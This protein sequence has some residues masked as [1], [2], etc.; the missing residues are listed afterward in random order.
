MMFMN[1]QR[2]MI[3]KVN[4]DVT[5]R[6]SDLEDWFHVDNITGSS[7]SF[8]TSDVDFETEWV[9]CLRIEHIPIPITSFTR[10]CRPCW[11][12]YLDLE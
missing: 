4:F 3:L 9:K 10:S 12:E 8:Q 6:S 2:D 5:G 7:L 1:D 11:S